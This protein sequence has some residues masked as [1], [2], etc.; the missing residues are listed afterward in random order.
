LTD[1]IIE[2]FEN[3]GY[4][5]LPNF[6]PGGLA[7]L[8]YDYTTIRFA[9][10]DLEVI[11][12]GFVPMAQT[13]YGDYLTESLLLHYLPIV[14][15]LTKKELAP[16]YSYLRRYK[17]GDNLPK[18]QDRY[19]CEYSITACAGY[20]YD[21]P[22]TAEPNWKWPIYMEGEAVVQEPGDA[23]LYKGVDYKHWRNQLPGGNHVQIHLHYID[24]ESPWYP[25]LELDTRFRLGMGQ[26]QRDNDM[27]NK[28]LV[29][30]KKDGKGY[31]DPN[32]LTGEVER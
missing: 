24:K 19:S 18:H 21:L 10:G 8:V 12:D 17:E 13:K 11:D 14:S 5:V 2:A 20:E 4:T 30:A 27:I 9:N 3:K 28:W 22:D 16:T 26:D 7:R 6:I 15:Q 31:R 1:E 25:D 23:L 32:P 29:Q